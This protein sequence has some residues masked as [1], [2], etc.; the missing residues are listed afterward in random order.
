MVRERKS[1]RRLAAQRDPTLPPTRQLEAG[2]CRLARPDVAMLQM[3]GQA[4]PD[5]CPRCPRAP[6][7]IRE[8]LSS[9]EKPVEVEIGSGHGRFLLARAKAHPEAHFVGIEQEPVRVARVDVAARRAGLKNVSL[10]GADAMRVLAS[11]FPPARVRAVYLFFPDPWPKARHQKHR[12]FQRPFL[13]VVC[14]LL[15]PGGCLHVATDH[16]GYFAWMADIMAGESRFLPA[17]PLV[18]EPEELTDFELKFMVQN[19]RTL[20]ASWRKPL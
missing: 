6:C 2:L 8:W 3:L 9:C 18:R 1:G 12:I 10:I 16:P 7:A 17:E 5:D 15:V 20:T 4:G 11:C 19:K 14:R 13:D